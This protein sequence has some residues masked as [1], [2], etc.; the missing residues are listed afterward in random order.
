MNLK[1]K[2]ISMIASLLL[3]VSVITTYINYVKDVEGAQAQLKNVSLPLSIDNIYTEVQQHM[4]KPLIVSSMMAS[5]TFVRDWILVEGEKDIKSIQKY[6]KEIQDKYNAFTS[7][8]VSDITKNYYHQRGLVDVVKENNEADKWYF[9]FN[10]K[11]ELYEVNLD[12]NTN[13]SDS[14]IMFINYKVQDYN[15]KIIATTGVGIKL[16]NIVDML[17]S[18]K[19]KY[20]YD[21]YFVD[22]NGE[23]ILHTSDLNKRGNISKIG[24]LKRLEKKIRENSGDKY[25]YEYKDST[26]MLHT[27]YIKE[28]N[29]YLFVEVDKDKYVSD[30][31]QRFYINLLLSVL[32]TLVIVYIIIHFINIYQARLEKIAHEDALTGLDNRR[33]FNHDIESMFEEFYR[34]HIKSL[35]LVILD[36]DDF[37]KIND[38][39][40]H[41]VGDKVLV[42]FAEILK[43]NI[44]VSNYI[45]RWGGEEFSIL[46]V[47]ISEEDI[48]ELFQKIRIAISKDE[49]LY[50]LI[51]GNIT[52][53]FGVGALGQN[54]SI[55]AL[56]SKVDSALYAA[57]KSG[58][59]KIVKA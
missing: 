39:Y 24:D 1:L 37:K 27:K 55:D 12:I 32:I 52:S 22:N 53:S 25:E 6:L 9:E 18:F 5:D 41:L 26:Y 17:D 2:I 13:F 57:K 11:D 44:Q 51:Q 40:G 36:I 14:L 28:L 49:V 20:K 7:F 8:L 23:I 46:L 35:T 19:K 21:V 33:K 58:K 50:D 38:T 3:S 47:D 10:S 43:E 29:L 54:E 15:Q 4:I 48:L 45:A 34:R 42:R 59:D 30:I 16:I 31:S 56:I